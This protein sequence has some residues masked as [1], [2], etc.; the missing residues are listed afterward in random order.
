MTWVTQCTKQESELA[1]LPFT[2]AA[3][4]SYTAHFVAADPETEYELIHYW[5]FNN[6]SGTTEIVSADYSAISQAFITYA[7]T[8]N[9]YLDERGQRLEDPVSSLNL[10]LDQQPEQ[11]AV[12]RARNPSHTRELIIEAPTSGYS[13]IRVAFA[14]TRTTNGAKRQSFHYSTNGGDSWQSPDQGYEVALLPQWGLKEFDLSTIEGV[15][16][17]PDML[18]KIL[19]WGESATG[20]S[21]NNR[22]DNLSV[23]GTSI[24]TGLNDF[25]DRNSPVTLYPNPAKETITLTTQSGA[26]HQGELA[27]FSMDGRKLQSVAVTSPQT[28]ISLADLPMGIYVIRF[29]NSYDHFTTKLVRQ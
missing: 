6:L 17:N 18:F 3:N 4:T 2:P 19:F 26:S 24:T 13:N 27:I 23:T 12:L 16:N 25:I 14:T 11:G 22:F 29:S 9:G 10:Y 8:G 1:I 5:H 21:G 20:T 28:T 15:A 7:G